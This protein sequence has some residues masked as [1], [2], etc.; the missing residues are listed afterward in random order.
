MEMGLSENRNASATFQSEFPAGCNFQMIQL[1]IYDP[2]LS[3]LHLH[4]IIIDINAY[5]SYIY[6]YNNMI[7]I[8]HFHDI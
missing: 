4:D 8:L 7:H 5:I 2:F 3:I 6:I 1:Y